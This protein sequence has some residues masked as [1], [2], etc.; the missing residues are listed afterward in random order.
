[1]FKLVSLDGYRGAN[2]L[3]EAELFLDASAGQYL[4]PAGLY[5]VK[6]YPKDPAAD[7]RKIPAPLGAA[8]FV[9]LRD[10][11]DSPGP[12]NFRLESIIRTVNNEVYKKM[13]GPEWHGIVGD[14]DYTKWEALEREVC[15]ALEKSLRALVANLDHNPLPH[16]FDRLSQHKLMAR[17]CMGTGHTKIMESLE[18]VSG[19]EV[20]RFQNF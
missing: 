11:H 8:Y 4:R 13:G 1:M 17:L 6:N 20:T 14:D 15:A 7:R 16:G 3:E 18:R 2:G 12:R 10:L 19:V 5:T 9:H